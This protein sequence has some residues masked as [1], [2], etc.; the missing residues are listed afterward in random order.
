MQRVRL[1]PF[2]QHIL[3]ERLEN[4]VLSDVSSTQ[5]PHLPARVNLGMNNTPVLDQGVHGSCVTFALTGALDAIIGKG[6]YISQLCSLE[7]GSYLKQQNYSDYS[8]WN[9]SYG[10]EVLEQLQKYGIVTKDYQLQSGCAGVKEYPLHTLGDKGQPMSINEYSS[11]A[12]P[13]DNIAT[14]VDLMNSEEVFTEN[15]NSKMIVHT[16][17]KHLKEGRRVTVGV[18]LDITQ[19]TAGAVGYYHQPFDSW[20]LTPQTIDNAKNDQIHASHEM[21][22]IGYDDKAIIR[23]G[24]GQKIKGLFILRNSWGKDAGDGGNYYMSYSYFEAL[25]DEAMV[26]IPSNNLQPSSMTI[27]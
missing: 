3:K 17:K 7:L 19:G 14:S 18:L 5:L 20:V 15:H 22:I 2:A 1:S 23:F 9:G 27:N 26:F 8:G 10:I 6:D 25:S 4:V 21:I 13:L 24:K 11:H 16:V 12:F